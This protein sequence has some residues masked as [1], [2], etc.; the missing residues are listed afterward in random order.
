MPGRAQEAVGLVQGL[1][2]GSG[3]R[4]CARHLHAL[5]VHAPHHHDAIRACAGQVLAC[6]VK[7]HALYAAAV[8]LESHVVV[9]LGLEV[10]QEHLDTSVSNGTE[11]AAAAGRSHDQAC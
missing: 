9:A 7:G 10:H 3:H 5:V 6:R 4:E 1:G 11:T 2:V 8:A